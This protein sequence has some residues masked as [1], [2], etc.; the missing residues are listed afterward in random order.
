MYAVAV[1]LVGDFETALPQLEDV[2]SRNEGAPFVRAL[3]LY[4]LARFQTLA[5][6]AMLARGLELQG[7]AEQIFRAQNL[8]VLIGNA[9][10]HR[11]WLLRTAGRRDE[12]LR[13]A[14]E[15]ADL[16]G[17][18]PPI[19]AW[20]LAALAA[21][22]LDLGRVDEAHAA[23]TEAERIR[24]AIGVVADGEAQVRL[25]VAETALA[26]GDPKAA[27]LAARAAKERLCERANRLVAVRHREGFLTRIPDNARTIE[28]ARE[29]G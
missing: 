8:P 3:A 22:R 5:N 10:I 17:P 16:L 23:A 28:L 9:R 25:M 6:P 20:A 18:A 4:M 1:A 14:E 26:A 27:R 29:I 7:A 15:A 13:A 2:A 11:S 24:T 21:A 19:Q 12:A